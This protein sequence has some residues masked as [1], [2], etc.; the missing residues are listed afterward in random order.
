MVVIIYNTIDNHIKS[1]A[2][3]NA[4][5]RETST[6]LVNKDESANW[7]VHVGRCFPCFQALWLHAGLPLSHAHGVQGPTEI[8]IVWT[9]MFPEI[10]VAVVQLDVSSWSCRLHPSAACSLLYCTVLIGVGRVGKMEAPSVWSSYSCVD[11]S[12]IVLILK[13]NV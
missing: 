8:L 11:K 12:F 2:L 9:W 3:L 10:S 7:A 4:G 6:W 13:C 1:C 5:R